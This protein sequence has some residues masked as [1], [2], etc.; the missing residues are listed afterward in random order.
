[1]A[2]ALVSLQQTSLELTKDDRLRVLI[3]VDHHWKEDIA[4]RVGC[5]HA[6]TATA[7]ISTAWVVIAFLFTLVD[8][9]VSL[10][11]GGDEPSEGQGV[12]TLWLWLLCLVVGW[13]WVP[14]FT[15][16][17]SGKFVDH[18]NLHAERG[19]LGR[20]AQQ[21]NDAID[22]ATIGSMGRRV[23]TTE[24]RGTDIEGGAEGL[25]VK[26]EMMQENTEDV[27]E[28]TDKRR[29]LL[30]GPSR[31]QSTASP[32]VNSE[33]QRDHDHPSVSVS[34]DSNHSVVTLPRSIARS[35]IRPEGGSFFILKDLGALNRD[36]LRFS[37]TFNYSR[38]IRH[39]VL[40]DDVFCA[41]GLVIR[42]REKVG[43]SRN[44]LIF[45]VGSPNFLIETD[46]DVRVRCGPTHNRPHFPSGS[47]HRDV[48]RFHCRPHSAGRSKRCSHRNRGLHSHVRC[49]VSFIGIH[50][51]HNAVD[52]NPGAHRH[53]NDPR[54]D[55]GSSR[56]KIFLRPRF[57]VL[58]RHRPSQD[59]LP[60]RF[61]QRGGDN[62]DIL[63][64]V[65]K[66]RR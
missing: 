3:S 37:A 63:L 66:F 49:R 40:V 39:L 46:S 29:G 14:T 59:F 34:Q 64:P 15:G 12:G 50:H 33:S 55:H 7:R 21:E 56:G 18:A 53:L 43:H 30:P 17:E 6:W 62:S 31:D 8:S 23:S 11:G 36:E 32:Q 24:G 26:G 10:D 28:G 38:I 65:L 47:S 54:S 57:H 4:H 61:H 22:V 27:R 13:L 1:M 42:E 45:E 2:K 5:R 9:F 44:H 41:L 35:L 58:H 25:K 48:Y 20:P 16:G 60:S 19:A 52:R 51:L